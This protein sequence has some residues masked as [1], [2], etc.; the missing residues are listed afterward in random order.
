MLGGGLLGLVDIVE[1]RETMWA[2]VA[3]MLA[4]K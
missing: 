4:G 2:R 3:G 1:T